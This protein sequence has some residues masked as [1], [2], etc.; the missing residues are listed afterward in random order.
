[1]KA[2]DR[3]QQNNT[4]QKFIPLNSDKGKILLYFHQIVL[5][6]AASNDSRDKE[7][8]LTDGSLQMIKNTNFETFLNQLPAADFCRIN[9]KEIIAIK[10]VKFFNHNEITLQQ[11]NKNGKNQTLALSETYR[12]DFLQKVKI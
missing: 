10:A 2:L 3:F 7:V 5:I 4:T 1:M 11:P 9:K 8:L 6:K 12:S